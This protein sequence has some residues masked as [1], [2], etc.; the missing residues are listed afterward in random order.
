MT[1]VSSAL[2]GCCKSRSGVAHVAMRVRRKEGAGG[3]C[4]RSG[5]AGPVWGAK[6]RLGRGCAGPSAANGVRRGHP[7]GHPGAS[8]AD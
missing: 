6:C 2:S 7:S 5:G 1:Y 8:S 3:P 4:A